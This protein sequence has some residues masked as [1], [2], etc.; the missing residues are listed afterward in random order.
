M[1]EGK[2]P[3]SETTR[4][5]L[6]LGIILVMVGIVVG[7]SQIPQLSDV[8]GSFV[9]PVLGIAFLIAAGVTKQY[10]FVVPGCILTGLGIGIVAEDLMVSDNGWPVVLGL[11]LGFIGIWVVDELFLH[12]LPR[13][14]RWWPLIPGGIL[15]VVGVMLSL[16]DAAEQYTPYVGAVALIVVGLVVIVRALMGGGTHGGSHGGTPTT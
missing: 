12:A 11:G 15:M 7:L 10:G 1:D 6:V 16:G 8:M 3:S 4:G 14:G 5:P 2:K 9:V 13:A